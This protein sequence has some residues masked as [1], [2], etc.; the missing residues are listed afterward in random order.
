MFPDSV[1]DGSR[2]ELADIAEINFRLLKFF[3]MI[4]FMQVI[5]MILFD[6]KFIHFSTIL[7][8]SFIYVHTSLVAQTKKAKSSFHTAND[9]W[10]AG[11]LEYISDRPSIY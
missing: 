6:C 10:E 3:A 1:C 11:L 8:L 9:K 2:Q 7:L 4:L 5:Y